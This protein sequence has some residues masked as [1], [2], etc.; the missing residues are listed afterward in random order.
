[1][2]PLRKTNYRIFYEINFD[3]LLAQVIW[4]Q[5]KIGKLKYRL[6]SIKLSGEALERS[7][8]I[9]IILKINYI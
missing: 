6:I 8:R 7:K 5:K 9:S 2:E 4:D 3:D 1:M